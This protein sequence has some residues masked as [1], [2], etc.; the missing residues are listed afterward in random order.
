M[1]VR[2]VLLSIWLAMSS[3]ALADDMILV[4]GAGGQD[5][6]T[7]LFSEWANQ[8]K[9]VA[10]EADINCQEIGPGGENNYAQLRTAISEQSQ[11][12]DRTSPLWL[13]LLGHG[14]FDRNVAKFNLDGK[15][16]A[17]KELAAWLKPCTRPLILINGFSCSGA[18]LKPLQAP[19]RVVITATKN[20]AELNFSR[21]GGYMAEAL[22]DM[23][24][25]LD[26]DDQV[27]LLEAFL[28][29][30]SNVKQ[31]YDSDA[32]LMT[33]HALLEDN[34]DGK[35]ISADF[36]KGIRVEATAKDGASLDGRRAHRYILRSSPDAVRL[37]AEQVVERDRIETEI[38]KLRVQKKTMTED[39]YF[40]AL[41]IQLLKMARLYASESPL[42]TDSND[43]VDNGE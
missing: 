5:E 29:A 11:M 41:E 22:N 1:I 7:A 33:E 42:E 43:S 28:L 38:E 4:I 39:D 24:A 14:T 6:Y 9:I 34:Q 25:D 2:F 10:K 40:A 27:S 20:G 21:F 17:A 16:V 37:T 13:V 23:T 32:R 12:D 3:A 19:E 35:G 8:W 15:D 31:F 36:F 18:F 30:S 26:H